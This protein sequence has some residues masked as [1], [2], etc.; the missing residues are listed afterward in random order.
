MRT[1]SMILYS[2]LLNWPYSLIIHLYIGIY[3][4]LNKKK[5]KIKVQYIEKSVSHS[6][7][8]HF[9]YQSS[10][11]PPSKVTLESWVDTC[12]VCISIYTTLSYIRR[13]LFSIECVYIHFINGYYIFDDLQFISNKV[14]YS[15]NN[16]SIC[17]SELLI[18]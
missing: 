13:F 1:F 17:R 12:M 11:L 9:Q 16:L 2:L 3:A 15:S 4:Y 18:R 7:G 5:A 6:I 14:L 8:Y 10:D